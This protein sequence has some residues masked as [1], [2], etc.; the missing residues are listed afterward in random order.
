MKQSVCK[1]LVNTCQS[2]KGSGGASGFKENTFSRLAVHEC[3]ISNVDCSNVSAIVRKEKLMA[4][5]QRVSVSA[6]IQ[7]DNNTDN[8]GVWSLDVGQ[9]SFDLSETPSFNWTVVLGPRLVSV[10]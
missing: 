9:R 4:C 10:S 1:A 8:V 2:E 3:G 7:N 6:T 5:L